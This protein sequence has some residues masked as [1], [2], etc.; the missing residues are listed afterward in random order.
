M[1]LMMIALAFAASTMQAGQ[2]APT[3]DVAFVL[4]QGTYTGTTT[5]AVSRAGEVSG[6]MKLTSPTVVDAAL[7]GTLKGDTWTFKYN[8]TIPEQGCTGHVEGTGKVSANRAEVKGNVTIGG[9]CSEAPLTAT[10]TFTKKK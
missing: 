1:R 8:Y 3:Y 6:T 2:A 10:F 7:G 4:E 9:G 5:F